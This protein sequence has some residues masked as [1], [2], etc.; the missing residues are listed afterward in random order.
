MRCSS[1]GCLALG[2][3][4]LLLGGDRLAAQ[5]AVNY[6]LIKTVPLP[7][8]PGTREYFDYLYVDADARRVYVTHG[9][10]VDVLNADDYALVGKIG[11]LQLSHAVVV[12]KE[13]GKGFVTDGE[14][15]KVII[16]DPKTL[17]AT[18]EV[19]TNQEDTDALVYDPVSKYLFSINGNSGNLTVID[20]VK[21]TVVKM[22]DLGGAAEFGV[23]D[24]KGTL[25]NNNEGK[26]DVA[27]IDT[28]ALTI[29]ARWPAAPAGTV[30]ALAMD[31]KNQRL[32][33][34]GRNPQ[35]LVMMDASNGK[36]I[37]SFPIT[38]GVDAAAF[39]PETGLLYVSTREGV[40][41][42]Y[43]EDSPDKLSE[44]QT[45]KTEYGAKT[46]A[47]DPKTHNIFVSTSDFDP[48]AAPTEKQPR[49]NPRA[50]QGN[51]R[52]LVYGR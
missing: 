9:S 38:A 44:V 37:Q 19:I 34:A 21:E 52:V 29:K 10:E 13:L 47:I 6:H 51:F 36:V 43:H 35:F 2:V 17:K 30:T 3:S 14:A 20:P 26:S 49:P 1:L 23:V 32:F 31:I 25:Y 50:K 11:G 7:V 5:S 27:V 48:P 28:R 33:S 24:G 12:L 18:G 16:F 40:V 39:E 41:H 15:K 45:L 4:L 42:I 22:M 46:L 8:A